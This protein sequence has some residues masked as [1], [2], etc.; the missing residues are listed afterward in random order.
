MTKLA[1]TQVCSNA[2]QRLVA[3]DNDVVTLIGT[4]TQFTNS[5][6]FTVN[7][8]TVW[9]GKDISL[10]EAIDIVNR[11]LVALNGVNTEMAKSVIQQASV[12]L[13]YLQKAV[14]EVT[15][16]LKAA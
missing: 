14:E 9:I 13:E 3:I 15:P 5:S 6:F 1:L 4:N 8:I 10:E 11:T 12:E 16:S 7:C 2:R